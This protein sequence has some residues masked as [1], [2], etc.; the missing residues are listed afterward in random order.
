MPF[1]ASISD[2][3]GR[4]QV[5][6]TVVVSFTIGT[7]LCAVSHSIGLMLVGRCL[8]GIG[9]GGVISISLII[10]S[11]IV[12]LRFR[13]Q[14]VGVLQGAWALGSVFG[15]LIGGALAHPDT[16]RWVFYLMLPFCGIGLVF[17]P[18][19][20]RIQRPEATWRQ[21]INR[22][23]W[24]GGFF[25]ISSATSLL[26]AISWGGTTYDWDSWRT[27]VP[28]ILGALG[29]IA[30]LIYERYGAIEPFLRHSLF[31]VWSAHGIYFGAFA[32]GLVVSFF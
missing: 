25:F 13:P 5:L 29:L 27:L 26:I 8:Q 1:T 20:V 19:F 30:T 22:V 6:F 12:P 14:Y 31:H 2:I 11:D 15:P 4:P 23:D 10:F 28:L 18:L 3:V 17:I 24:I 7:I 9:G 32:Q 21:M 16:W